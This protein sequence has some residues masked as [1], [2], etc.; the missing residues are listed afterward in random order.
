MATVIVRDSDQAAF[1]IESG[2][3]VALGGLIGPGARMRDALI[4]TDAV[5]AVLIDTYGPLIEAPPQDP[6]QAVRRL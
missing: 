4:V 1:L 3:I 5:C 6:R 2:K